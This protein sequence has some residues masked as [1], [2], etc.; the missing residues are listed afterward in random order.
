MKIY[1]Y[2]HKDSSHK[3]QELQ[4]NQILILVSLLLIIILA[5]F[6]FESKSDQLSLGP[7]Q[8]EQAVYSG[9]KVTMP[10]E[11]Q[12]GANL[13][14][15]IISLEDAIAAA[16][17]IEGYDNEPIISV[18]AAY[19]ANGKIWYWGIKTPK[20]TITLKAEREQ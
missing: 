15:G 13:P 20:G 6:Y 12:G 7:R 2:R 14:Q 18:E 11:W 9:I 4:Y 8:F 5:V 10:E 19:G 17:R 16:Q 3:K 1:K